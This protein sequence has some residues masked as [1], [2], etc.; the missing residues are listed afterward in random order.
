MLAGFNSGSIDG[1]Y[2]EFNI[3]FSDGV[4]YYG[5]FGGLIGEND[6]GDIKNSSA[7]G[8]LTASFSMGWYLGGLI[9][10]TLFG[11]ITNCNAAVDI[12]A[13][14]FA[15]SVTAIIAAGLV[16]SSN[17][18][19]I[20]DCYATGVM[21]VTAYETCVGGLVGEN[22]GFLEGCYAAGDMIS[23]ARRSIIA[24]GLV[25][26]NGPQ[27]DFSNAGKIINC[28]AI[29]NAILKFTNSGVEF[30]A[31]GLVGW[32]IGS[33]C[34]ISDCFSTGKVYVAEEGYV[35][36]SADSRF[37]VGGLIGG[38]G[39]TVI[40]CY[41]ESEVEIN[42]GLRANILAGGLI[43]KHDSGSVTGCYAVGGINAYSKGS[44]SNHSI[45]AG[46]LI[47]D[48]SGSITNSYALSGGAEHGRT[49]H[50]ATQDNIRA[51]RGRADTDGV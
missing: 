23:S 29:G 39:G 2:A 21:D 18:G 32:T 37:R 15:T 45:Y 36:D 49:Q 1:C 3:D 40:N 31:G 30:S 47:G 13:S 26:Q 14:G 10:Q 12:I 48:N 35:N 50:G 17:R 46:G 8:V 4:S 41:S 25:G 5:Y 27:V 38:S 16:G 6:G 24:G 20:T 19:T 34:S 44:A 42:G 51:F 7:A 9:G 22:Y 11:S 43:G 28:Y 33:G